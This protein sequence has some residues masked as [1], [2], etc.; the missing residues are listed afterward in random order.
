MKGRDDFETK[1]PRAADTKGP[2][3]PAAQ[4]RA[5]C[6]NRTPRSGEEEIE[7]EERARD[8]QG[9]GSSA[10]CLPDEL[11]N[12]AVVVHRIGGEIPRCERR[13]SGD[14]IA[15]ADHSEVRAPCS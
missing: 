11:T 15:A 10:G 2:L 6:K 9:K 12:D 1:P 3:F 4:P 13:R 7:E 5:E 14:H 8:K